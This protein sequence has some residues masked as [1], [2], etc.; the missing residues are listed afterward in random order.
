MTPTN[1]TFIRGERVYVKSDQ[2]NWIEVQIISVDNS[3]RE[4]NFEVVAN[5]NLK[6]NNISFERLRKTDPSNSS[7]GKK[8][9]SNRMKNGTNSLKNFKKKG[10]K[11][12]NRSLK[13]LL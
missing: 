6:A 11:K 3:R 9:F 1:D 2:G 12:K 5:T 4:A 7:G 13:K 8:T 10:F